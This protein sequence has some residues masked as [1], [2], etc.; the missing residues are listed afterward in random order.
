VA[1][2]DHGSGESGFTRTAV[3]C[4]TF[5]AMSHPIEPPGVW[6]ELRVQPRARPVPGLFLDRDGVVIEDRH[7]VGDP[8]DVALMPGAAEMIVA[9]NRAGTLVCV[10]T[11]QSGIDR[12]Y[13]GWD[14]F[15][16]VTR[17]IDRLLG[18]AG[19]RI[20]ALAACPFHPDFTAGYGPDHARWRKPGPQMILTLAE[21]LNI[22]RA[23]SWLVGD[24]ERDLDAA[25]AAGLAGQ[26]M[27]E[28]S[29]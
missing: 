12:G 28:P 8:E 23:Q 19:A 2:I 6:I 14:E 5:I 25:R 4:P 17:R 21:R 15:A 11:N 7:F 16:A 24:K 27:F 26:R 18:R 20:D 1:P 9:A 22:D 29:P 13:F 10:V 3:A